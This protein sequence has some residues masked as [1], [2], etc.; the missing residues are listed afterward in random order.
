M[1]QMA[2][3][4]PMSVDHRSYQGYTAGKVFILSAIPEFLLDYNK[5]AFYRSMIRRTSNKRNSCKKWKVLIED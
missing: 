4:S 2:A 3:V 1:D 5:K